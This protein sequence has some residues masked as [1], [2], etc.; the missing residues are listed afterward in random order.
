MKKVNKI[1]LTI[2][3]MLG[4]FAVGVAIDRPYPLDLFC[5]VYCLVA[6]ISV[7]IFKLV[8]KISYLLFF[9]AAVAG[10]FF[11]VYLW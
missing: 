7:L 5:V 1:I 10:F 6:L 8:N 2:L 4:C 9:L 3:L 11:S